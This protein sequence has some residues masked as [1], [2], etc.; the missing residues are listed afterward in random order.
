MAEDSGGE[1][2]RDRMGWV[3][4]VP[5]SQVKAL[6]AVEALA[7]LGL[8]LPGLTEFFRAHGY[9]L[10]PDPDAP[11]VQV[12]R[13]RD[14]AMVY[15]L[16]PSSWNQPPSIVTVSPFHSRWMASRPLSKRSSICTCSGWKI[17]L[18]A[19]TPPGCW[20]MSIER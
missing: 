20:R 7:A 11:N 18:P 16:A 1:K 5:P 17:C 8:V 2:L 15:S 12:I 9:I 13:G 10:E 4:P 3:D 6:G 14:S 19:T